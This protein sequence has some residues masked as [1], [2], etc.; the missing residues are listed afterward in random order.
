M[1]QQT[2]IWHKPENE[3]QQRVDRINIQ[4]QSYEYCHTLIAYGLILIDIGLYKEAIQCSPML[5]PS[6]KPHLIETYCL[7]A[8][9][10]EQERLLSNA[11]GPDLQQRH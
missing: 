11:T 4:D 2:G 8:I 5:Q 1:L 9:N 10:S 6:P 3:L 7:G